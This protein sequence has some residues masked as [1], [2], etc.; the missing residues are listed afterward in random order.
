MQVGFAIVAN[1]TEQQAIADY[2]STVHSQYYSHIKLIFSA[3]SACLSIY[4]TCI[5][6]CFS[7]LC[8]CL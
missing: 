2:L 1:A 5:G 3:N 4:M 7:I 8:C 6:L